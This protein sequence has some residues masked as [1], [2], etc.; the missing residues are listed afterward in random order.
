[1]VDQVNRTLDQTPIPPTPT[2]FELVVQPGEPPC[3]TL[4]VRG[5]AP[6]IFAGWVELMAAI[7]AARPAN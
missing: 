7:T 5:E 3:G 2:V 6:T 4:A 1:M